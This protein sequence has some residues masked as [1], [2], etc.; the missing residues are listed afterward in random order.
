MR[1]YCKNVSSRPTVLF[2]RFCWNDSACQPYASSSLPLPATSAQLISHCLSS[3][4]LCSCLKILSTTNNLCNFWNSK[5]QVS[6]YA[7]CIGDEILT[8]KWNCSSPKNLCKCTES[9]STL[10][11]N[12]SIERNIYLS[13]RNHVVTSFRLEMIVG[14]FS[15]HQN[16]KSDFNRYNG[17]FFTARVS[18][19]DVNTMKRNFEHRSELQVAKPLIVHVL[20]SSYDV[21]RLE[22]QREG[23]RRSNGVFVSPRMLDS[24]RSVYILRECLRTMS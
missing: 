13:W 5:L 11:T 18:Q 2:C 21:S 12:T 20:S 23:K 6:T 24:I 9:P 4:M 16:K 22:L 7:F 14:G 8:Q 19:V 3:Q 17:Y 15:E 1:N 10:S